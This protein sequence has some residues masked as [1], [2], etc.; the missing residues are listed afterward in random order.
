M[1]SVNGGAEGGHPRAIA[2]GGG[3]RKPGSDP[4]V[5]EPEPKDPPVRDPARRRGPV[6]D[7][8]PERELDLPRDPE[9]RPR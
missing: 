1:K 2:V 6:G 5:R 4:P 7:P 9:R 8:E 3:G